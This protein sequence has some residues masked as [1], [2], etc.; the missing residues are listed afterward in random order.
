MM[1]NTMAAATVL[2]CAITLV[3]CSEMETQYGPSKGT[4]GR[5]SLNGFGALRSGFESSGY[6]S[7]DVSRLTD[8]ARRTDV[9][10]WTPA[11]YRSIDDKV[12]RWFDKWLRSGNKTL[13]YV[14]PDSGSEAD[15]WTQAGPLASPELRMEFHKRAARSINERAL[16]RLNREKLT[17]NGWFEI[18][19]LT[20]RNEINSISGPWA[21]EADAGDAESALPTEFVVRAF[22]PDNNV[23]AT[24]TSV[25]FR[26]AG[27]TG[28]GATGIMASTSTSP[29]RTELTFRTLLD[30]GDGEPIAA[31]VLSED[32]RNSKIIVIAGGSLLTNFAMTHPRNQRL[33]ARII[34]TSRPASVDQPVAGFLTSDWMGVPVSETKP[35]VP[36]ATG[37]ELLTVWPLSLVTMH[38]VMLG[39]V[40]CLMLW[41]IL[42]RPQRVHAPDQTSFGHHLDAVAGLM[43]RAGGEAYARGRISEYFRRI[44]GETSGPWVIADPVDDRPQAAPLPKL[45]IRRKPA[46]PPA[47]ATTSDAATSDSATSD[48]ATSDAA[49][50][51]EAQ[52]SANLPNEDPSGEDPSGEDSSDDAQ[53]DPPA[54]ID[55]PI[56]DHGAT[57]PPKPANPDTPDKEI[58]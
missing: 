32:W 5:S 29:T 14:V 40:V 8:R 35:G 11:A 17:S 18:E 33:A 47:A 21:S 38:G 42:G 44:H 55:D 49:F 27:A 6:R 3:G 23:P 20:H 12:T 46:Q 24:G 10:V 15:Y 43:N 31:E 7:R 16:W 2:C 39:L 4:T 57:T 50:A 9:I 19:P 1:R 45:G 26:S 48:S 54:T 22:D 56:V 28:P 58:L 51:D 34:E 52:P 53:P 36:I 41:P 13:V 37:M 30:A 25:G